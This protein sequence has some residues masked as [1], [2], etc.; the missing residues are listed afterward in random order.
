VNP[1]TY[2]DRY[3][4][5]GGKKVRYWDEGEGPA[6]VLVHGLAASV[7]FWVYNIGALGSPR[8]VIALDLL[9]FGRS[10]KEIGEFS[11][12]YSASFL[13]DFLDA[14]G[15]Q[16]ASLVG[17]SMGG[18]VCLQTA[19]DY[20]ARVDRLVLVDPAGFG[21]ELNPLLRLWSIP[22]AGSAV[23]WLS[24]Q[25]FPGLREWIY[26]GSGSITKAWL[27]RAAKVLRTPG[28]RAN[29]VQV[30]R[31]GVNLRGQREELFR[32]LHDRLPSLT[33][34]TMIIWGDRD[35]IVPVQ[36]AYAANKLIP[37]SEVRIIEGCGHLP[38]LERPE[39]FNR[40][41]LGF[42]AANRSPEPPMD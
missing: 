41:V 14:V 27:L 3:V 22:M 11:L 28:V 21:R 24:Q 30:A 6:V 19:V 13:M 15:L 1:P 32:D 42:L 35:P 20:P 23:F 16:E 7:E 4:E 17:N 25:L 29:A 40:L 39:E 9:G 36:H 33:M 10:D 8:R 2:D 37:N 26:P 18:L 12:P 38:Q 5:V 31:L 34:P